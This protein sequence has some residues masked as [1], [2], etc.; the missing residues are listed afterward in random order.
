MT[1]R[2]LIIVPVARKIDAG[3]EYTK[4]SKEPADDYSFSGG[5]FDRNGAEFAVAIWPVPQGVKD[6]RFAALKAIPGATFTEWPDDPRIET[7]E[8]LATMGLSRPIVDI[9]AGGKA[10]AVSKP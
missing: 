3:K 2:M 8:K 5:F 7:V 1:Y 10:E 4:I 6:A 9:T